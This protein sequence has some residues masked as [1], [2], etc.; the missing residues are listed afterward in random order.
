MTDNAEATIR[1]LIVDDIAE[2][3]EN[4]RKLLQFESDVAVVGAARTGI[5]AI[6]MA[7]ETEPD[8]VIMDIGMPKMNGTNKRRKRSRIYF[9]TGRKPSAK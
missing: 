9:P 6:E 8:V 7:V 4:I 5:E 3:R 1:V 2:T